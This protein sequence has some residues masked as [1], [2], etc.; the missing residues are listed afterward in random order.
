MPKLRKYSSYKIYFKESCAEGFSCTRKGEFCIGNECRCGVLGGPSCEGLISGDYCHADTSSC[1]CTPDPYEECP[2]ATGHRCDIETD[3]C[4]C[5]DQPSCVGQPSGEYCDATNSQCKC[6]PY[7]DACP[8]PEFCNQY[9]FCQC[10]CGDSC[11][12]NITGGICDSSTG[13]CSCSEND[14]TCTDGKIC[15]N[16]TCGKY[17]F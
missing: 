2:L 14:G 5:G 4:M 17:H 6:S 9:E 12:G 16:G 3:T 11:V 15:V 8:F 7:V 1:T 13:T 10:G